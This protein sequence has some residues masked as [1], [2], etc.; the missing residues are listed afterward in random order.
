MPITP[1]SRHIRRVTLP[2]HFLPMTFPRECF[3]QR[4]PTHSVLSLT[5]G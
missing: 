5:R 2:L 3:P 4:R 1:D